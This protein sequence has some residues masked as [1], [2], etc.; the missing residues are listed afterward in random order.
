MR[1]REV[2]ES[3]DILIIGNVGN[4]TKIKKIT[5]ILNH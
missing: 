1:Q 4:S 5:V 3:R 2:Y